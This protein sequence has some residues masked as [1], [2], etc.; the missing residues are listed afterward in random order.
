MGSNFVEEDSELA[1]Y[2]NGEGSESSSDHA[3][4]EDIPRALWLSDFDLAKKAKEVL[5]EVS[6]PG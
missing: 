5:G 3:S 6:L 4:D 2:R 1:M